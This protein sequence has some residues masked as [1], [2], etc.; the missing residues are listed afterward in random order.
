MGLSPGSFIENILGQYELE[1]YNND[2]SLLSGK[3]AKSAKSFIQQQA[4][5]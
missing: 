4:L 3:L 2:L 5:P 1:E